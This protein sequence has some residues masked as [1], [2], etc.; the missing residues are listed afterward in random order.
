MGRLAQE[1][2]VGGS[3]FRARTRTIG[4]T[5]DA[6]IDTTA[7]ETT[8]GTTIVTDITATTTDRAQGK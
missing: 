5:T 2:L 7:I 1:F 4:T 8:T 3:L 6:T